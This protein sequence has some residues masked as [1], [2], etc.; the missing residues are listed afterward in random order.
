[1]RILAGG[2]WLA[3]DRR[4]NG[5]AYTD[6]DAESL[7]E[8]INEAINRGAEMNHNGSGTSPD[9]VWCVEEVDGDPF[10]I[11]GEES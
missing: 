11:E 3:A 8:A 2:W 5:S 6:V 4:T 7:D 10:D 1:L 9:E